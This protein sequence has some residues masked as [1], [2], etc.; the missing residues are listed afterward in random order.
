[1][2]KKKVGKRPTPVEIEPGIKLRV[3]R[4]P[5]KA[6]EWYFSVIKYT[7]KQE[8]R[9]FSKWGTVASLLAEYQARKDN[10]VPVPKKAPLSAPSP[11]TVGELVDRW[12]TASEADQLISKATLKRRMS[13]G[14]LIKKFLN[15]KSLDLSVSDQEVFK[16]AFLS[17]Y[18]E[19]SF[20]VM[21]SHLRQIWKWGQKRNYLVSELD[22]H[23]IPSPELEYEKYTPSDAEMERLFNN[24]DG[25]VWCH[26]ALKVCRETGCR[27][28]ELTSI[29][30][31]KVNFEE[32]RLTLDGKTGQRTIP[33]S[34]RLISVLR[35][36]QSLNISETGNIFG[37][38]TATLLRYPNMVL[39]WSCEKAD[40]DHRITVHS[41]RRWVVSRM[42]RAKVD[43]KV[44]A[45][46]TGHDVKT[47]LDLYSE[48]EHFEMEQAIQAME[49]L[50]T[51]GK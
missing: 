42:R 20:N 21:I 46:I 37:I 40:L 39:E 24:L 50:D 13:S 16:N 38:S 45:S 23:K 47:M 51:L 3:V 15:E 36:F 4:G 10:P 49:D 28:G 29:K 17:E 32:R 43:V 14:S 12:L 9:L 33:M 41:I 22:L 5:N 35:E 25:E 6:G 26:Y 7:D 48:I 19:T 2:E 44:A 27:V 30:W 8:V 1:M 31:E 11:Q 18:A 34:N